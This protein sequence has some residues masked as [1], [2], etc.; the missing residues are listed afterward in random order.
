MLLTLLFKTRFEYWYATLSFCREYRKKASLGFSLYLLATQ[1]PS[2]CF[3]LLTSTL[4][5]RL[6]LKY[7]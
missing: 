5:L 2:S 7:L 3:A 1:T 6:I 4:T